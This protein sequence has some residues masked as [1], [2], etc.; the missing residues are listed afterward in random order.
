[1]GG[2]DMIE[3]RLKEVLEKFGAVLEYASGEK[4]WKIVELDC[5]ELFEYVGEGSTIDEAI[6][7]AL[8][9]HTDEENDLQKEMERL[10]R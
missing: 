1:M 8:S 6:N 9:D 4:P 2:A 5:G 3:D 7:Q 10:P